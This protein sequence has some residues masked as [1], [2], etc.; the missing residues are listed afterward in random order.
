MFRTCTEIDW[1]PHERSPPSEHLHKFSHLSGPLTSQIRWEQRSDG[2][3]RLKVH[4]RLSTSE[5]QPEETANTLHPPAEERSMAVSSCPLHPSR[6][7]QQS[8]GGTVR[9]EFRYNPL[10]SISVS[11][12]CTCQ[13]TGIVLSYSSLSS[14]VR[15]YV[16][17]CTLLYIFNLVRS[18]C[19]G[20]LS[21]LFSDD[22]FCANSSPEN[23]FQEWLSMR[24]RN[25]P[26]K[27]ESRRPLNKGHFPT[28]TSLV[29][30][31]PDRNDDGCCVM[32]QFPLCGFGRCFRAFHKLANTRNR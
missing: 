3:P 24:R 27:V 30:S 18:S 10:H 2:H 12:C 7:G 32:M 13:A 5:F 15:A 8:R 26:Q 11:K 19:W 9:T 20:S 31:Y 25:S 6:Y 17:V 1:N 29:A 4:F 28:T 23:V 21:S 14:C 16:C 22:P